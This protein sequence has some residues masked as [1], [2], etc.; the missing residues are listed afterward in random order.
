MEKKQEYDGGNAAP[1][2]D[3]HEYLAPRNDDLLGM[4][5]SKGVDDLL[6]MES[7]ATSNDPVPA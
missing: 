3:Y 1:I 2:Y 4:E 6:G 5:E 7:V